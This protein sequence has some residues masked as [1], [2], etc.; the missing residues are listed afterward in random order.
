MTKSKAITLLKSGLY[1]LQYV[2]GKIYRDEKS[3]NAKR[4][5]LVQRIKTQTLPDEDVERF[6]RLLW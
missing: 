4:M 3:I 1:N 2:A 5:R 6:E